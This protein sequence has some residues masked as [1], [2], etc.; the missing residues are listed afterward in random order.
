MRFA[1]SCRPMF[2]RSADALHFGPMSHNEHITLATR[3]LHPATQLSPRLLEC[4]FEY[5]GFPE[6]FTG[7]DSHSHVGDLMPVLTV[8]VGR[9]FDDRFIQRGV[10]RCH[11]QVRKVQT[12]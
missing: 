8:E 6:G 5:D 11:P 10:E 1:R 7:Y 12:P 3:L 9:L 4:A 2:R